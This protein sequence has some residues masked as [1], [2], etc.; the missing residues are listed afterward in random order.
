MTPSLHDI[1]TRKDVEMMVQTFYDKVNRDELL[2][3]IF[4]QVAAVNWEKHLPVMYDFWSSVLFGEM[5]YK[6]NP[7][8]KHIPLPVNGTH[9]NRW[10]Q[11]FQATVDE[12]FTGPKAE[13]AK[14][15]AASIAAIFQFKIEQIQANA[16]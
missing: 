11:L 7:F 5:S 4:S 6:G 12:L 2:S 13:E 1:Q 10:I 16:R 8:L 3:P 9:F 15:R 14:G